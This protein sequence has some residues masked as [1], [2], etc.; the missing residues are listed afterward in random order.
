MK[1]TSTNLRGELF[2]WPQRR[3]REAL[4]HGVEIGIGEDWDM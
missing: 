2:F 4:F 1:H 3:V